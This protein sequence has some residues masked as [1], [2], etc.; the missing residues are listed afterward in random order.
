MSSLKSR[1]EGT[2]LNIYKILLDYFGP[3]GWWPGE[4]RF[5]ILVGAVLTQNTSWKNVEKS[6]KNLKDKGLLNFDK[7]NSM[8]ERELAYEIRSSGFYNLKARRLKNLLNA[9]SA[10]FGTFEEFLK[11]NIDDARNFLLSQNGIGKETAD[12]IILYAMDKPVFVVDAYTFRIFE[13]FGI[14]TDGDYEFVR[15]MVEEAFNHDVEKLKEFHALLV[16]LGKSKCKKIPL[17]DECPLNKY[18]EKAL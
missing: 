17:C 1:N 9:I 8:D 16:A 4:S 15:N 6:I 14:K 5:E 2:L 18:C 13:R 11:I 12:S 3:Q 10:K 7:M